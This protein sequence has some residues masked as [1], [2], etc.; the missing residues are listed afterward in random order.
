MSARIVA[1]AVAAAGIAGSAAAQPAAPPSTTTP[2]NAEAARSFNDFQNHA[3]YCAFV[4]AANGAAHWWAGSGGPD[5][6]AGAEGT[7]A[8][9]FG[10]CI[11]A[12]IEKGAREAPCN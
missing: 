9:K 3:P 7:F 6:G 8:R 4:V 2:L 11:V 1:I 12:F 5:P 10:P